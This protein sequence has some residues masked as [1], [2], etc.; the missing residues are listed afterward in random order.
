MSTVHHISSKTP[1]IFNYFTK[2]EFL[3]KLHAEKHKINCKYFT[4]KVIVFYQVSKKIEAKIKFESWQIFGF[5]KSKFAVSLLF[6]SKWEGSKKASVPL[7]ATTY[8]I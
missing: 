6:L 1:K 3:E 4:I 5:S 7:L 8:S 2:L